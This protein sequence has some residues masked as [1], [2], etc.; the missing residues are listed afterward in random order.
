MS[1]STKDY[2]FLSKTNKEMTVNIHPDSSHS[3][4]SHEA[5]LGVEEQGKR[6][7]LRTK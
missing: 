2:G 4:K 3:S 5:K 7:S 6:K 1:T